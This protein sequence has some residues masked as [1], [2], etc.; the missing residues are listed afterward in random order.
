MEKHAFVEKAK[1]HQCMFSA[2]VTKPTKIAHFGMD[3]TKLKA[4]RC[5]HQL[6][7][8]AALLRTPWLGPTSPGPTGS[9][10]CNLKSFPDGK[11][12]RGGS[13]GR[14]WKMLARPTKSSKR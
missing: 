14:S 13:L 11:P 7:S 4:V 9:V 6:S 12:L 3:L 10:R 5:Q 8:C 1:F 2:E